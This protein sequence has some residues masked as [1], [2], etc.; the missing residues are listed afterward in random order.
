V[1]CDSIITLNLT[2]LTPRQQLE[3]GEGQSAA[4]E[5]NFDQTSGLLEQNPINI[6]IYPNPTSSKVMV[7]FGTSLNNVQL[8]IYSVDG[9]VLQSLQLSGKQTELD[10]TAYPPALYFLEMKTE[11]GERMVEK[12]I[13]F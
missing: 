8:T 5:T 3:I 13:K 1:G 6:K 4:S 11:K 10:L 2:I 12:L 7:D 9:R